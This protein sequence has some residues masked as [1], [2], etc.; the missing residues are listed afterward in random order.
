MQDAIEEMQRLNSVARALLQWLYGEDDGYPLAED[1]LELPDVVVEGQRV[2]NDDLVR[3]VR[4]LD[5]KHLIDG[6]R[7]DQVP[8]PVRLALTAEGRVLVVE[9][10]GWVMG[11]NPAA[12][13][14]AEKPSA[15]AVGQAFLRWLYD[16]N[17]E[18]PMPR[19]F[20]DDDRSRFGTRRNRHQVTEAEMGEAVELL[21]ARGLVEGQASIASPIPIRIRL[22]AA[23][24]I[25]VV[26]HEADPTV[27][28]APKTWDEVSRGRHEI[29]KSITVTGQG[30]WVVAHSDAAALIGSAPT[31]A[32]P[33]RAAV[34]LPPDFSVRLRR[35]AAGGH[36]VELTMVGPGHFN[37][38]VDVAVLEPEVG[39]TASVT[40]HERRRMVRDFTREII[41]R[42]DPAVVPKKIV[43]DISVR[44]EDVDPPHQGWTV[45]RA[46]TIPP[47][48]TMSKPTG[49]RVPLT[50]TE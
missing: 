15:N 40:G 47:P 44:C 36:L 27:A 45:H 10:D 20:L 31:D 8:Y 43:L 24:R 17:F 41:I 42:T 22:T 48:A 9:N 23:G 5:D 34:S 49:Q 39:V 50:S 13:T 21:V 37:V 1:F 6:P 26:D 2:R 29:N 33:A 25:C 12:A 11:P 16:H 18:Q 19:A 30:N 38:T 14:P 28:G 46:L 3:A 32:S 4:F 7:I 35:W